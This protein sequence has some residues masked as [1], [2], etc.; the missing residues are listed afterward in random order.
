MVPFDANIQNYQREAEQATKDYTDAFNR[1]NLTKTEQ[2]VGTRVNLAQ[3][4]IVGAPEPSKK[5]IFL[6]IAFAGSFALCFV[7]V[8]ALFFLDHSINNA[9]QLAVATDM[10]VIGVLN[11]INTSGN[12]I[13]A[14]WNDASNDDYV[15][16][17]NLLRSIRFEI[18]GQ[19]RENDSKI[20][21]ITS[22]EKGEGRS[23]IASSLAYAFAM[24]GKKVLLIGAENQSIENSNARPELRDKFETFLI[25]RELHAEHLITVL[26]KNDSNTSLLEIQNSNSI[27]TGFDIL[28]KDFDIIIIDVNSLRDLNV[29]KEWLL[30]TDKHLAV[31]KA[32]EDLS[33]YDKQLLAH[34]R[35]QPGFMGW[36]INKVKLR[37]VIA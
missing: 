12:P 13:K 26:N 21:G 32:G 7:I 14:I 34:L 1:F 19:M 5:M 11:N 37:N 2:S 35:D 27:R 31:F 23:F 15:T 24:T 9:K 4:G 25:K 20:L 3:A 36:V 17:K 6:I 22:L 8:V 18:M 33:D 16:F 30:F 29:A 28:R 10:P